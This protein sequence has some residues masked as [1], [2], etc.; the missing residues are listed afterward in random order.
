MTKAEVHSA[1]LTRIKKKYIVGGTKFTHFIAFLLQEL[2]RSYL[3]Y[4][5]SPVIQNMTFLELPHNNT[6]LHSSL[7]SNGLLEVT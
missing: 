7:L 1:H 6:T 4:L 3:D 5:M 2:K